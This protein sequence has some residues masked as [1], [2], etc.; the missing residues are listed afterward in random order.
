MKT[1]LLKIYLSI[2]LVTALV[3]CSGGSYTITVGNID[4]KETDISGEYNSFTGHYFKKLKVGDGEKL[5]LT[6]KVSTDKGELVAKVIDK[7]GN[8]IKTF[9]NGES[10]S[11]NEPGEYKLQVE[12]NEH[13][14]S[15]SLSW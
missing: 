10:F 14:G 9:E 1:I 13:K 4:S 3:A 7:K 2:L 11:L 6:Y 12:G 15:F 5:T 8:T